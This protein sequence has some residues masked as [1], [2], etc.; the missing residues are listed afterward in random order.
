[1][2]IEHVVRRADG[3]TNSMSNLKLACMD[4][5]TNR[6]E[7]S[8]EEWRKTRQPYGTTE[9]RNYRRWRRTIPVDDRWLIRDRWF[10]DSYLESFT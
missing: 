3:G 2:T 7:R 8:F 10:N 9:Q 1:M 5:N 6:G 4:C